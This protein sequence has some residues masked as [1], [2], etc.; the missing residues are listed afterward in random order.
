MEA[1]INKNGIKAVW[2]NYGYKI[3]EIY[4]GIPNCGGDYKVKTSVGEMIVGSGF[5]E[6]KNMRYNNI[7]SKRFYDLSDGCQKWLLE[8]VKLDTDFIGDDNPLLNKL[9]KYYYELTYTGIY[10]YS[11][12]NSGLNTNTVRYYLVNEGV[13]KII[14]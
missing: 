7:I 3:G 13:A 14:K 12:W 11:G 8:L 1:L 5:L 2:V 9:S 4:T 10:C 6:K